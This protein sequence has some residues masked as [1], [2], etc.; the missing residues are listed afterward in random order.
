[1][2]YSNLFAKN[3]AY[4][5]VVSDNTSTITVDSTSNTNTLPTDVTSGQFHITIDD[6]IMLVTDVSGD[7][8]FVTR[9]QENTIEATHSPDST[10]YLNITAYTINTINTGISDIY[11]G[12]AQLS[13]LDIS[14]DASITGTTTSGYFSGDGSLLTNVPDSGYGVVNI[15]GYDFVPDSSTGTNSVETA[16]FGTNTIKYNLFLDAS[17][18]DS[19]AY[20]ILMPYNYDSSSVVDCRVV[21]SATDSTAAD[22]VNFKVKLF[23]QSAGDSLDYS[24]NSE[25]SI[26][27]VNSTSLDVYNY[28]DWETISA[29]GIT[30]GD[31]FMVKLSRDPT[32]PVDDISSDVRLHSLLLRYTRI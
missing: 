13:G 2:A 25:L 6:E 3:N 23:P 15:P 24:G 28:S 17:S 20:N 16:I 18:S 10:A 29:D 5:V 19:Y 11:T 9:A 31:N 4:A 30:A 14:G 12:T 32:E 27:A 7:D 1:M 26:V 22:Y 8:Y 21:W